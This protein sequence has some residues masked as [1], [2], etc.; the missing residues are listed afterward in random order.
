MLQNHSQL[1]SHS[2]ALFSDRRQMEVRTLVTWRHGPNPLISTALFFAHFFGWKLF[3]SLVYL[4]TLQASI[5]KPMNM[6]NSKRHAL[7]FRT[8][9]RISIRFQSETQW[10]LQ[11]QKPVDSLLQKREAWI[12]ID[13]SALGFLNFKCKGKADIVE[14]SKH[15]QWL[16]A[17]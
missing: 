11:F 3:P 6:T 10:D 1:P 17:L 5:S 8:Y 7:D 4:Y 12:K 9:H 15:V 13:H 16:A 2:A 14:R